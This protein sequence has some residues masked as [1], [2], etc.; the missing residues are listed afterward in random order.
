MKGF[1]RIIA[2]PCHWGVRDNYAYVAVFA[3]APEHCIIV[4]ACE[5]G[6]LRQTLEREK[7]SPLAVLSTHHHW[8]HV[9]ANEDMVEGFGVQVFGHHRDRERIPG[10]TEALRGG[11]EFEVHGVHFRALHV[12]GHTQ[13]SLLYQT[14]GIAFTGDTLFCAGCGRLLEGTAEQLHASLE[15]ISR[16]LADETVVYTGHE[17]AQKNLE[18]AASLVRNPELDERLR[19][20]IERRAQQLCCAF[21]TMAVERATNV[22]LM[23]GD[24]DVQ[25]RILGEDFGGLPE[26]ARAL[27]TFTRL[28]ALKD[29]A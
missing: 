25:S 1:S 26:Q 9:G 23:C 22:F 14:G 13:G 20:V 21:G 12:P 29:Q 10:I 11:D 15:F 27:A 7:L 28:R 17:Y 4:D 3:E 6:P 18:F 5:S 8:D 2:V 19:L 16:E 24:P